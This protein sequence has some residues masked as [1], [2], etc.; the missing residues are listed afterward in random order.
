MALALALRSLDEIDGVSR[1]YLVR[2]R[3]F[4]FGITHHDVAV[5]VAWGA[6]DADEARRLCCA[7]SST[8]GGPPRDTLV[9][10]THLRASDR[11]AFQV[12]RDTL[13]S[14]REERAHVVRRQA[15]VALG[16][17][18]AVFLRGYLAMFPPPY[19][20]CDFE[21]RAD[22]LTWLGHPC[23][24][25][26]VD[27]IEAVRDDLV[28][29]LR[30]WLSVTELAEATLELAARALGTTARTIQRKLAAEATGFAAELTRAQIARAK[31]LMHETDRKLSDIALDVG[32]ATPSVF[33][34]LFRRVTGESPSQ[35]RR[36]SQ[37]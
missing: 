6:F 15:I 35:W 7:W 11:D 22:A 28:F 2:S 36:R 5:T 23:C 29:Q 19:E 12:V 20:L 14:R 34:D 26:E 17:Y 24:A 18:G 25:V 3:S 31:R 8:F 4:A 10:V 13:E 32:C 21:T 37:R 33:S 1:G 16:E 27:E 9:D 30:N